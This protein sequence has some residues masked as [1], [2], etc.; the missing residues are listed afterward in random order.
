MAP[1]DLVNPTPET[2]PQFLWPV[3]QL[4]QQLDLP[5]ISSDNHDSPARQGMEHVPQQQ[6][7]FRVRLLP[8]PPRQ[9]PAAEH[10]RPAAASSPPGP[11]REGAGGAASA[12][13]GSLDG[14]S[15]AGTAGDLKSR[16]LVAAVCVDHGL[17]PASVWEATV[18]AQHARSLGMTALQVGCM[19]LVTACPGHYLQQVGGVAIS[20][21][22]CNKAHLQGWH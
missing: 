8:D 19:L 17:R 10:P 14:P 16:Q 6:S 1:A 11:G 7:Y 5:V 20:S 12:A 13:A 15:A 4:R 2:A 18:G 3:H 21:T 9:Q 22:D